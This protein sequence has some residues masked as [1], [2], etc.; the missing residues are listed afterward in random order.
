MSTTFAVGNMH[1]D[2]MFFGRT[3]IT[4]ARTMQ[5]GSRN[6]S[7]LPS[8][9]IVFPER[10]RRTDWVFVSCNEESNTHV[11]RSFAVCILARVLNACFG[12]EF[13]GLNFC[14]LHSGPRTKVFLSVRQTLNSN[15][16]ECFDFACLPTS[17][18]FI[19]WIV[20]KILFRGKSV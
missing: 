12:E 13:I 11:V 16:F 5:D 14:G 2:C 8:Q 9:K 18:V 20:N 6:L 15:V 10:F 1:Y 4:E 17:S 7:C 3:E 19:L